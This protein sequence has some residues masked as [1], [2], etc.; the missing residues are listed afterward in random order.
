MSCGVGDGSVVVIAPE[1]V[2][3]S[4]ILQIAL[5][6]SLHVM[7]CWCWFYVLV[8]V[9]VLGVLVQNALVSVLVQVAL[10]WNALVHYVLMQ[11]ALMMC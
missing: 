8:H 10:V 11:G 2:R 1:G 9:L 3:Y 6:S 4:V 7:W 5:G